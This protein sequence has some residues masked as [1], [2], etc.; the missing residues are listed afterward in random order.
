ME[1]LTKKGILN[2]AIISL[3]EMLKNYY[4]YSIGQDKKILKQ[5]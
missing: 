2:K 3:S 5:G 1:C 4:N